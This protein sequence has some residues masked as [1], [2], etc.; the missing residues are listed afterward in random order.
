MAFGSRYQDEDEDHDPPS[1]M[2]RWGMMFRILKVVCGVGA[3]SVLAGN[4]L[5]NTTTERGGA[6]KVAWFPSPSDREAMR[7][8]AAVALTSD[9]AT[10]SIKLDPCAMPK[11]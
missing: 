4:I 9:I 2:A 5:A 7:H 1:L 6:S 8:A 3:F 10:G 11:K